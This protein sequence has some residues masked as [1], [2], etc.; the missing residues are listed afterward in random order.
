MKI[1]YLVLICCAKVCG[2]RPAERETIDKDRGLHF[3][4]SNS[5]TALAAS[6]ADDSVIKFPPVNPVLSLARIYVGLRTWVI[7]HSSII[8]MYDQW[9]NDFRENMSAEN[10][11]L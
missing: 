4:R 8:P 5:K 7:I 1:R 2:Y 11:I 9:P 3:L 10:R 6:K